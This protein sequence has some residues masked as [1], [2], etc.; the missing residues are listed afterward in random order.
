VSELG[1]TYEEVS[2]TTIK[3]LKEMGDAAVKQYNEMMIRLQSY[4]IESQSSGKAAGWTEEDGDHV[5]KNLRA[6]CKAVADATEAM[7]I[8]A[9]NA[10]GIQVDGDQLMIDGYKLNDASPDTT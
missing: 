8:V 5:M 4:M 2:N 7:L 1:K 6:A 9:K 10:G 3:V